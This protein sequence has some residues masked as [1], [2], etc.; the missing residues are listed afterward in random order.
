MTAG[1]FWWLTFCKNKK[2]KQNKHTK[3]LLGFMRVW[4]YISVPSWTHL[5]LLQAL[6]DF[7]PRARDTK[8]LMPEQPKYGSAGDI[9]RVYRNHPMYGPNIAFLDDFLLNVYHVAKMYEYFL[10]KKWMVGSVLCCFFFPFWKSPKRKNQFQ[11]Y[12][13]ERMC[14]Y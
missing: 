4:S 6:L 14:Q 8:I 9:Q 1:Y 7:S 3:I 10:I 2:A 5:L 12:I 13:V 11:W